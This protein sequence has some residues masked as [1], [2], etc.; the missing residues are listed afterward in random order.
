M[1]SQFSEKKVPASRYLNDVH[2]GS[3]RLKVKSNNKK[4]HRK[5]K[6]IAGGIGS[7]Q[8]SWPGPGPSAAP[9]TDPCIMA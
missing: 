4:Q 6:C 8:M 1:V 2:T 5:G 9:R 7:A 3:L